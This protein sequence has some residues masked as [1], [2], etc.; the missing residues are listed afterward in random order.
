MPTYLAKSPAVLRSP[1]VRE[2]AF[3]RASGAMLILLTA[4]FST[5]APADEVPGPLIVVIGDSISAA[6][7]IDEAEGWV[8]LMQQALIADYPNLDIL[9]ASISGETTSGGLQRLPR[10]LEKYQPAVVII[11]LGGNDGLR[12]QSTKQMASNIEA[13]VDAAQAHGAEALIL[14]MRIPSNYGPAYTKKFAAVFDDVAAATG[15]ALVPFLLAPIAE[16]REYFQPDGVHPTADAQPLMLEL[17]LP[18]IRKLLP[19]TVK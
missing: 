18:E 7:G 2:R 17:V 1:L 16:N 3:V 15:A 13:M 4:F 8:N 12:G 5:L 19:E 9:N 14:G 6:Y 10:L 11:E